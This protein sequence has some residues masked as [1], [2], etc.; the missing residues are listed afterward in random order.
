MRMCF[1]FVGQLYP[2]GVNFPLDTV[3]LRGLPWTIFVTVIFSNILQF[4]I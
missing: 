3:S 2:Q 4:Q 1:L